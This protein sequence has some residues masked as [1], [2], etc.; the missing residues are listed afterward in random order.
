LGRGGKGEVKKG[1]RRRKLDEEKW[2]YDGS[3]M[4][5]SLWLE[6]HCMLF[7]KTSQSLCEFDITAGVA[8]K[9]KNGL[10]ETLI[11]N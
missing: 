8:K 4:R 10:R 3:H 11:R 7:I 9:T 2:T 6:L 5:V 1:R